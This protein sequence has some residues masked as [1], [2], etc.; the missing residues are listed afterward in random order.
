M[1][2]Q[3]RRERERCAARRSAARHRPRMSRS[4]CLSSRLVLMRS[5]FT[6]ERDLLSGSMVTRP[7]P[8]LLSCSTN[9]CCFCTFNPLHTTTPPQH[10]TPQHMQCEPHHTSHTH[11]ATPRHA[12][13]LNSI[14]SFSPLPS[15][16]RLPILVVP[17]LNI[18]TKLPLSCGSS[19]SRMMWGRREAAAFFAN[20][21]LV[22]AHS[23]ITHNTNE[24]E[25]ETLITS[26][27]TSTQ[28]PTYSCFYT[29]GF[30]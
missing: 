9:A 1:R 30:G 13:H 20:I 12:T 11:S 19:L 4:P 28:Q 24:H 5:P 8:P 27:I 7:T 18:Y 2:I 25:T 23:H 10:S 3:K 26:H 16:L 29:R 6:N 14:S 21:A 15:A 17:I 22:C